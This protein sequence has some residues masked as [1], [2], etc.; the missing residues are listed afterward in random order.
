[1]TKALR[2]CLLFFLLLFGACNKLPKPAVDWN[3]NLNREGKQPYDTYIAYHSADY[4]FPDAQIKPIYSDYDFNNID[5][6]NDAT[7]AGHS[8][9]VLVGNSVQFSKSE[10]WSILQFMRK[11]NEVLLLSSEYDEQI[12]NQFGFSSIPGKYSLPLSVFNTGKENINAL[13]LISLPG[14]YFG[15]RG[16]DIKGYFE[17]VSKDSIPM[18]SPDLE[19]TIDN[20]PHILGKTQLSNFNLA[21]KNEAD[22]KANFMQYTVGAGHL[23]VVATPLVFSNYF[24]LQQ[25]N[26]AY[27]EAIWQAVD[28]DI[29]QIYWGNFKYRVPND[30]IFLILWRNMA[31]RFFLIVILVFCISYLVFQTKRKQRIVPV[32]AEPVNSSLAFIET[33][34]MLY[35]N[36]GDNRNLAIKMEQHFMEW[37]RTRFNLS[38]HILD[39]TF[40]HHLSIKSGVAAEKVQLLLSLIHQLRLDSSR[41]SDE[42]LFELYQLIQQ[43]YKTK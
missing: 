25:K 31:T 35:Y 9:L 40:A 38:T 18:Q 2:Y 11:G 43:F 4:Y 12:Q 10:W 34:G 22:Y 32:I 28:G 24:L 3:V 23:T 16:R 36:K 17:L 20:V 14:T 13:N 21:S 19:F 29:F 1:M 39:E 41:V 5:N 42:M 15:M 37:V 27:L 7:Q 26:R 6:N 33:I 30:S 8:L